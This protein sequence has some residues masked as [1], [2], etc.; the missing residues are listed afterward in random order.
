[1]TDVIFPSPQLY[2]DDGYYSII[3]LKGHGLQRLCILSLLRTYNDVKKRVENVERNVIITI[4]EPE[5]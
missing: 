4:E 3:D 5:I 2:A 1:M